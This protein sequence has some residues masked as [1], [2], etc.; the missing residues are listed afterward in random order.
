MK[1]QEINKQLIYIIKQL[2]SMTYNHSVRVM[3]ISSEIEEY[4]G[5]TDHKLM[6]AS[7]FHDVGKVYMPFNILDKNIRL[8]KL[9]RQIIDLHPYIGY[10]MLSELGLDEDIC[11]I[12]LYHHGCRPLTIQDVGHYDKDD[13][14]ANALILHTVDAFEALT[15]DRPYHRGVTSKEALKILTRE[16]GYDTKVLE[17]IT[18]VASKD[19]ITSAIHRMG[20]EDNNL[21]FVKKLI[22]EMEL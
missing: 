18:E 3:M 19:D 9:E 8:T 5:M 15:S 20:Q 21:E 17:Y 14:Y 4:L 7:I 12:I 22:M 16:G 13:I 10:S 6:Y 1:N 11:R 2:D